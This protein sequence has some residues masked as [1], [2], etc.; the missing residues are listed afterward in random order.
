MRRSEPIRHRIERVGRDEGE[1]DVRQGTVYEELEG[2]SWCMNETKAHTPVHRCGT[3]IGDGSSTFKL[4]HGGNIRS[5]AC[6][7]EPNRQ[8]N[9]FPGLLQRVRV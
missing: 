6:A 4:K 1:K 7:P 3:R 8:V 9:A 2:A 5:C